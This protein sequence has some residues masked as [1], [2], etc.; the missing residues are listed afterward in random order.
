MSDAPRAAMGDI[1]GAAALSQGLHW[2]RRVT[3]WRLF[4]A[5]LAGLMLLASPPAKAASRLKAEIRGDL[6]AELRTRIET[7]VGATDRPVR[8][9][10][11]SRQRA[12]AAASETAAVLRSEGYYDF[13]VRPGVADDAGSE[14][15]VEVEVGPRFQISELKVEWIDPPPPPALQEM[16]RAEARIEPGRPARALDVVSAEARMLSLIQKQGYADAFIAPRDV[17]VD[18]SDRT[19]RPTFRISAGRPVQLESPRLETEGRTRESWLAGLSP[20]KT[21]DS[22]NPDLVAELEKSLVETG[23]YDQVSVSLGPLEG[24][25]VDGPRPVV[26]SLSDRRAQRLETGASYSS[27]EGLGA[28]MRWT[29][30]NRLGLADTGVIFARGSDVDSRLGVEVTL[31]HWRRLRQALT[32]YAAVFNRETS[33]YDERGLEI[34]LDIERK[35]SEVAYI[36]LGGGLEYTETQETSPGAG[37]VLRREQVVGSVLGALAIDQTDDILDPGAGWRLDAR[38]EPSLLTGSVTLSYV[39]ASVQGSGYLPLS[40][41]K[42]TLLAGRI[43]AG[44]IL[45]GTISG[46]PASRRFYAGGGGSVRGYV[47]QGIGPHLSDNTP[48]GGLSLVEFSGELRHRLNSQWGLVAFIDGGAVG[49]AQ[50]PRFSALDLGV[51]LGVRFNP[52]F[53]PIRFDLAVPLNRRSDDP[54]Y[55]VYV[56]IGQSF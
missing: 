47:Y 34:R 39:K 54:G 21:G 26:V 31:P 51:G 37:R 28:D 19:L 12:N 25:P 52:G 2:R 55:Q 24:A 8:N 5:G 14:P 32:G 22:Y 4:L 44:S 9:R 23:V 3:G 50:E 17:I 33:A 18:H 6:P 30:F 46:V 45:G 13:R 49:P 20:W 16:A 15:F 48:V 56:S 7:A 41:S 53:G 1:T 10:F 27:S 42:S 29:H 38:A 40:A 35:R 36:T 11:D 43:K